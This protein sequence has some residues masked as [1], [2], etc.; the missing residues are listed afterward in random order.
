MLLLPQQHNTKSNYSGTKNTK[1]LCQYSLEPA[2]RLISHFQFIFSALENVFQIPV[3][4][5]AASN[6]TK[7]NAVYSGVERLAL[8]TDCLPK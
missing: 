8:V 2:F 6:A 7:Q 5:V 1:T 3:I 4:F